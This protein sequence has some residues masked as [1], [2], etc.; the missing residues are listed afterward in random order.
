M[1]GREGALGVERM[2]A[3]LTYM[4]EGGDAQSEGGVRFRGV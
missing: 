3:C 1:V 4:R 2:G